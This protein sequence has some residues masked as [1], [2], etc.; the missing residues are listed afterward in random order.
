MKIRN[1][2]DKEFLTFFNGKTNYLPSKE[3]VG[4]KSLRTREDLSD[5]GLVK[6]QLSDG[7]I[8]YVYSIDFE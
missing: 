6:V 7:R 8:G 1:Y 2:N 3:F 4:L 5:R